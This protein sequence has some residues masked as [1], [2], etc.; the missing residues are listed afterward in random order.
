M[1][2]WFKRSGHAT[3]VAYLALFL[4]VGGGAFA[5]AKST[6]I[7]GS[8]LKKRSV[9]GAKLKKHTIT[10]TEVNLGKLGKVPTAKAADTATTAGTANVAN[11][12]ATMTPLKLTRA[13]STATGAN[14]EVASAAAS[15]VPLYEDSHFRL[16]GKCYVEQEGTEELEAVVYIETLQNGAIFDSDNDELSGEAPEG[17]LN[18]GTAELEREV[19]SDS[20]EN[21][22]ANMQYEGDTEFGA[23]A[24]DLYTIQGVNMVAEKFGTP[25]AGNGPYGGGNVCLFSGYVLHS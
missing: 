19:I 17:Y 2:N 12:L 18:T 6:K 4:A 21:N 16:Y 15:K 5:I 9:A 24:A 1:L 8:K 13:N 20:T 14:F 7:N 11:S 22:E 3:V 10:G 25:V 23:T